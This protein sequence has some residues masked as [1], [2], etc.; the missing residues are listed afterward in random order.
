MNRLNNTILSAAALGL[1][2][3]LAASCIKT[4]PVSSLSV[5][6]TSLTLVEGE[7]AHLTVTVSPADATDPSVVWR[8]SD[9]A[10]ATVNDG[11]VRAVAPGTATITV[12]TLDG[13]QTASCAVTVN[14]QAVPV[15]SVSLDKTSL[16]MLVGDE[17]TLSATVAPADA[18]IKTVSWSS[19]N[20]DVATVSDGKVT[21]VG[22]GEATITVTTTDGGKTATCAVKVTAPGIEYVA[23]AS[24]TKLPDMNMAR[25]DFAFFSAGGKYVA[26][27]G[28][29]N[30]FSITKSAEY[31]DG[32]AW[33][34]ITPN[35]PHDMGFSVKLPSGKWMIGGGC[36]S[37]SGIGQSKVVDIYDPETQTFSVGPQ[38]AYSRALPH[39]AMVG[40]DVVVSGNWYTGDAIEALAEGAEAFT[41]IGNV[42]EGRNRPYILQCSADDAMIFGSYATSGSSPNNVG[43][44]DFYKG[45]E[46]VIPEI[47]NTYLPMPTHDNFHAE[48]ARIADY[49]YLIPVGKYYSGGYWDE[50]K[51]AYVNGKD[52]SLMK[53][54]VAVPVERDGEAIYYLGYV[55]VDPARKVALLPA[56]NLKGSD[57]VFYVLRVDY[58]AALSG[59]VAQ[60]T[61]YYSEPM[62]G[63][64]PSPAMIYEPDGTIIA[65]GGIS[66]SNFSPYKGVCAF[67][68]F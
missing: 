19:D 32:E 45:G 55:F 31:F 14:R 34:D 52:F 40:G 47:F 8:S 56:S 17:V 13:Q 49:S 67:K 58:E 53:T 6:Q 2:A 60:L 48:D 68:P 54:N 22:A 9:P 37:G 42:S 35:Y 38:L 62:S 24:V 20:T 27:G 7:E 29:T 3:L 15:V 36:S 12:A 5:S 26:V 30:S 11:L 39:A 57:T 44:V 64:S 41:S 66:N 28:H 25:S 33:H 18:D 65:A 46:S 61:M 51:L 63:I 10:V 50:V 4:I 23:M 21:A 16:E 59:G 43:Q 1:L